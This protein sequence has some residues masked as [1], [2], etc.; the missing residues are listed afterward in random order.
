MIE[1]GRDV[2][3]KTGGYSIDHGHTGAS[4]GHCAE[5]L[6]SFQAKAILTSNASETIIANGA[7][8]DTRTALIDGCVVVVT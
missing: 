8:D 2:A 5:I 7:G 6:I 4:E 3:H 1:V